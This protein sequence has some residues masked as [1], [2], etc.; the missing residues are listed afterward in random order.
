MSEHLSFGILCNTL[1]LE[2]WQV[3][4][5][6]HLRDHGI[7]LK[8]IIVKESGLEPPISPFRSKLK[9]LRSGKALFYFYD[10]Y[11]F[12]P[13]S[14]EIIDYNPQSKDIPRL[15]CRVTK[16]G[17]SSHFHTSDI[18]LI[19]DSGTDFLLRFGFGIIGGEILKVP[20]FGIWS[21][22]HGDE[23]KYRGGPP[24][25]WEILFGDPVT[26]VILQQLN[27]R[28]DRGAI[29]RKGWFKTQRHSYKEQLDQAY[30]QTTR[31]PL[32]VCISIQNGTFSKSSSDSQA[33]LYRVPDNKTF[34]KFLIRLIYNRLSFHWNELTRAED[35]NIG[36]LRKSIHDVVKNGWKPKEVQWLDKPDRSKFIADPFLLETKG[37]NHLLFEYYCY[38]KAKGELYS[39]D[40]SKAS[41]FPESSKKILHA[42]HHTSFPFSFS[43]QGEHYIIPE[44]FQDNRIALYRLN[45]EKWQLEYVKTLVDHVRG[46]D[47]SIVQHEGMWWLFFT[48]QD[49]PSVHLYLYYSPSLFEPFKP[50]LNNPVKTDIRSSRPAGCFL[51]I[52]NMLI[53]PAQDCSGHYGKQ[54]VLNKISKLS[55]VEFI[56]EEYMKI[57][58]RGNYFNKGLHTLNGNNHTTV[59]DGKEFRFLWSNFFHTIGRKTAIRKNQQKH[60]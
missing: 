36:I 52:D 43:Y 34:F 32:Q 24:G 57:T 2:K 9:K 44:S 4:T 14:M 48:K 60:D 25:F 46:V 26:G 35:W 16:K 28:L 10:R 19:R 59:I 27:E 50:H 8:L 5:I 49:L 56:E 21:F 41:L 51:H 7:E 55:T 3:E 30:L 58:P 22:H 39:L 42:N 33:P 40:I 54:V 15:V 6:N 17:Y 18:Q 23:Q 11:F 20:R 45:Q 1:M 31:W 53:R 12:H 47:A 13:K 38:R 29:L 37:T